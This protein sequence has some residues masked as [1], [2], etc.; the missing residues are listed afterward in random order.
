MKSRIMRWVTHVAHVA[1]MRNAYKVLN[2][3]RKERGHVEDLDS[4]EMTLKEIDGR[5]QT[6]YIWLR[7]CQWWAYMNTIMNF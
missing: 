5:L 6:V 4:V 2:R 3:K 7:T 1:M